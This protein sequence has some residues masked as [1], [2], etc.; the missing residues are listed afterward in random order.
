[1]TTEKSPT[2]WGTN[3]LLLAFVLIVYNGKKDDSHTARAVF[4]TCPI[5]L[6]SKFSFIL[7]VIT[8]RSKA[9]WEGA[10]DYSFNHE[11]T[12]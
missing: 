9:I 7:T 3:S 6:F 12:S 10:F 5:T 11:N 4:F 8:F 1:M 2:V